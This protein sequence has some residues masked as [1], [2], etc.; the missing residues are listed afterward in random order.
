MRGASDGFPVLFTFSPHQRP[1]LLSLLIA[2]ALGFGALGMD[3]AA[4]A[5]V[6]AAVTLVAVA[7]KRDDGPASRPARRRGGDDAT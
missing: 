3:E 4:S 1:I 7:E 2:G 6:G 5:L